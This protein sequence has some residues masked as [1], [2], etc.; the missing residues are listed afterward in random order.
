MTEI[1][2]VSFPSRSP[3]QENALYKELFL[4]LYSKYG[5]EKM[6]F[7]SFNLFAFE[8]MK[9]KSPNN[10]IKYLLPPEDLNDI[11]ALILDTI[12]KDEKY[13][14]QNSHAK[15]C[16]RAPANWGVNLFSNVMEEKQVNITFDKLN[17]FHYT[18]I[19]TL[20]KHYCSRLDCYNL[21]IP[22]LHVDFQEFELC[23]HC[24]ACSL[25][26]EVDDY[27]QTLKALFKTGS[28]IAIP[29]CDLLD[30]LN[31]SSTNEQTNRLQQLGQSIVW[32]EEAKL[33]ADFETYCQFCNL[34]HNVE[35]FLGFFGKN[36]LF[37]V[38]YQKCCVYQ[39]QIIRISCSS[40]T[41]EMLS[42]ESR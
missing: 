35:D 20:S 28:K 2:H 22:I 36:I 26:K 12:D 1:E 4:T 15:A 30:I 9:I 42:K 21:V 24:Q 3:I 8:E 27:V 41:K 13:G 40:C 17:G 33:P 37:R 18:P 39:F 5:F 29:S 7:G 6:L 34:R 11:Q 10:S 38:S 31:I 25:P 16:S 14:D 19:D 32:F 23:R